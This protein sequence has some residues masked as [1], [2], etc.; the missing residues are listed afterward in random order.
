MTGNERSALRMVFSAPAASVLFL[1]PV[2]APRAAAAPEHGTVT[3]EVEG[4]EFVLRVPEHRAERARVMVLFGGRGWPGAKTLAH[5]RLE[6]LAERHG[7]FLLAPSLEKGEYWE[8]SSG[9]GRLLLE[10]VARLERMY[11]VDA[12]KLYLYGYS[13]GGQCAALFAAFLGDRVGAWGAHAC[14]VYPEKELLPS[15]PAP[16]LLT[17]GSGDSGRDA[18]TRQFGYVYRER[19]GQLLR[20]TFPGGHELEPRALELARAWFDAV[21]AGKKPS[22][23]G[24]DDSGL[25]VPAARAREIDAEF[26]NPLFEG[27]VEALWSR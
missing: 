5:F 6:E 13:A 26:R 9:T 22:V 7:V 15:F 11:G 25:R 21:M 8:P 17:C 19:G 24:D 18:L 4:V 23:Y 3:M 16:A 10:A 14:G 2:A 1:M 12:G 20:Q 27:R